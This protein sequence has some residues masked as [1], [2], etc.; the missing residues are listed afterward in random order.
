MKQDGSEYV[1]LWWLIR[2]VEWFACK[3]FYVVWDTVVN[4]YS[5]DEMNDS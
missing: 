4:F 5:C 2:S 1:G 3:R